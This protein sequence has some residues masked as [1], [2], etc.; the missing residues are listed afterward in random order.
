MK[1]NLEQA[2]TDLT[3]SKTEVA[4]QKSL[5]EQRDG[6]LTK[7]VEQIQ[8]LGSKLESAI[9]AREEANQR[10]QTA[11]ARA[12]TQFLD[13]SQLKQLLAGV[14]KELETATSELET[15]KIQNDLL[16]KG[17]GTGGT[18]D[19]LIDATIMGVRTNLV[20]LS[21]GSD[22]KVKPGMIFTVFRGNTYLGEVQVQTVYNDMAGAEI[23]HLVDGQQIKEG[24]NA[25]TKTL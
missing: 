23:T 12:D 5:L 4:S 14:R 6:R 11:V 16:R 7:A 15:V 18:S 24:D 9:T 10:A 19:P 3:A 22:D 25:K 8:A 21:V 13:N 20:V 1:R 17:L 2:Q